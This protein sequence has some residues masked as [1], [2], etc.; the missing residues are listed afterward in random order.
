MVESGGDPS[1][2]EDA[3]GQVERNAW[4]QCNG[5]HEVLVEAV[6]SRQPQDTG[7]SAR[8]DGA[9]SLDFEPGAVGVV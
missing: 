5:V 2:V 3:R 6:G 8:P 1:K 9:R 4:G 7:L